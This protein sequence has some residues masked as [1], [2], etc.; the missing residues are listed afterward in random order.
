MIDS[1]HP[2]RVAPPPMTNLDAAL[3]G[4]A[5]ASACEKAGY[6]LLALE[7]LRACKDMGGPWM[8]ICRV[9]KSVLY[10]KERGSVYI[11][12]CIYYICILH[13][14]IYDYMYIYLYDSICMYR[15]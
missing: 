5:A 13:I 9:Q 8:Q 2:R 7:L 11:Y 3:P 12:I 4:K 6:W 15:L 10:G 14:C 1:G